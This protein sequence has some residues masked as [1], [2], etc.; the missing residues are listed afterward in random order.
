MESNTSCGSLRGQLPGNFILSAIAG[1][2]TGQSIRDGPLAKLQAYQTTPRLGGRSHPLSANDDSHLQEEIILTGKPPPQLT[3]S[4][5]T[6]GIS[7]S[8]YPVEDLNHTEPF[9]TCA[10]GEQQVDPT[11]E[12]FATPPISSK[13]SSVTLDPSTY[14]SFGCLAQPISEA[15]EDNAPFDR[16][17]PDEDALRYPQPCPG[18]PISAGPVLAVED[19][20]MFSTA[21]S[22]DAS[23]ITCNSTDMSNGPCGSPSGR[24]FTL[25]SSTLVRG[26]PKSRSGAASRSGRPPMTSVA[27]PNKVCASTNLPAPPPLTLE[28]PDDDPTPLATINEGARP[29]TPPPRASRRQMVESSMETVAQRGVSRSWSNNDPSSQLRH[30]PCILSTSHGCPYSGPQCSL[31]SHATYVSSLQHNVQIGTGNGLPSS[32]LANSGLTCPTGPLM[33]QGSLG[34]TLAGR[35]FA[36]TTAML[37]KLE[38]DNGRMRYH[39]GRPNLQAMFDE[40]EAEA[41]ACGER[42]VALLVCGNKGVLESCLQVARTRMGGGVTFDPHFESFGF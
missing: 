40:V 39:S 22:N 32:G 19:I 11:E 25:P 10:I 4:P 16:S 42:R 27:A 34:R 6:H 2:F 33:S 23:Y 30:P 17:L 28:S 41:R 26:Q 15:A 8:I 37:H 35:R 9:V 21:W 7:F 5:S 31:G 1:I 29:Y 20:A 18:S 38:D 3:G 36:S 24:S 14:Q 13:V 12:F